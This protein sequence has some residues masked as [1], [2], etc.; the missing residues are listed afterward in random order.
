MDSN[1]AGWDRLVDAV[2]LKFGLSDHGRYEEALP[3][4]SDLTRRVQFVTFKRGGQVYKMERV[5][6]P[7][8]VERKSHYHKS[9]GQATRFENIYD[10]DEISHKTNV[11]VQ[12]G[13][14]WEPISLEDLALD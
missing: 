7:A 12:T 3:D 5:T 1:D 9:A 14:D 10:P 4:R 13:S 11:Y 8:I 2:D 6:G